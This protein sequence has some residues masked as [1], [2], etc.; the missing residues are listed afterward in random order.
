MAKKKAKKKPEAKEV[1]VSE[2]EFVDNIKAQIKF[3]QNAI[4]DLEKQV[5]TFL[6]LFQ[7]TQEDKKKYNLK[8]YFVGNRLNYERTQKKHIGF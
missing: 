6:E 5:K 3:S 2:E 7:K 8:Y 4:E 1:E